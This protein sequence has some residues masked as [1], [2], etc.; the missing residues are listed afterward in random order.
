MIRKILWVS[1]AVVGLNCGAVLAQEA[2]KPKD[3]EQATRDVHSRFLTELPFSDKADFDSA[4]RGLIAPLPDGVIKDADGKLIWDM[5]TY[6]T[7]MNSETAPDTVNPSLWRQERLNNY[8]GLFEVTKGIHQVRGF[9][10]SNM[11]IIEGETGLIIID[12][13]I[14]T[15]TAAAGLKLYHE[16]VNQKPV[17]AVIYSHSHVDHY[18]G[19]KGVISEDDVKAGKVKVYAPSGFLEHAVVENVYAGNAMS[20]RAQYMYGA[21]LPKDARGQVGTGLGKT[22]SSGEVTLI[23]PTD[24]IG[25]KG[26]ATEKATIDGIEVEFQLTPGTEAPSEMNMFFPDLK[27]LGAAENATHT[28]HNILTLRGAVVRD[29]LIWSK[30]L[31]DT[32]GLYA[33]KVDVVFAQH[34]WPTWGAD[35]IKPFL[36]DQRDMYKYIND[37]TLRLLNIGLTPMEIAEEL[38]TLPPHLATKWYNRDYYGSMSHNVRAVYQRYLG[39]YDGNPANLDPLQPVA[40]GKKYVEFMGGADKAVEMARE[41][42]KKGEFRWVAQVMNH[43]VFADPDNKDAKE[44]LADALEQIGYQTENGTWRSVMLMG[45]FELRNGVPEGAFSTASPDTI[46]AMTLDMYF[47]YMGIRLN[48][49]KAANLP[50]TAFNWNFTD[51]KQQYAMTLRNGALTYRK[52][53]QIPD[54]AV[55]LEL[56]RTALDDVTLGKSTFEKEIESGNIKLTG[57]A[58]KFKELFGMLDT[59]DVMFNIVTP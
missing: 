13:L 45:A 35:K 52:G 23:A 55:G 17:V 20:R 48:G 53:V 21:L 36:A 43:V 12:P 37:Q 1:T 9:D 3:A 46:K 29:P 2:T 42:F 16:K 56:T 44:L 10:L 38:K 19:V 33:D 41:S 6:E 50:E 5:K 24:I 31:D 39:F 22:T 57:D 8:S 15:A 40:A 4:S 7:F 34:H 47:D 51:T 59:F 14:S 30:Y 49:E 54:A 25:A 26:E 28:L 18:G 58:A 27:A 32:I 11:T